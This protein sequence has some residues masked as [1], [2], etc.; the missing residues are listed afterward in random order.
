MSPEVL[1]LVRSTGNVFGGPIYDGRAVDVWAMGVMLFILITGGYPFE[2]GCGV[3]ENAEIC[4][5]SSDEQ[6]F[7]CC[8]LFGA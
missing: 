6:L 1:G 7:R 5:G 8:Q 3:Q 2:V 4:Q